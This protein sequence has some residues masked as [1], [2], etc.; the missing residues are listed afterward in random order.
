METLTKI[1]T[2]RWTNAIFMKYM[3]PKNLMVGITQ[4]KHNWSITTISVPTLKILGQKNRSL[5]CKCN[6]YNVTESSW[7]YLIQFRNARQLY[8]S[9]KA[10]S[11]S[12]G[13]S[14]SY[15]VSKSS[16]LRISYFYKKSNF[17]IMLEV[18]WCTFSAVL[19]NC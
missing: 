11:Y 14:F 18:L 7:R 12:N 6:I 3:K 17:D 4:E 16:S 13:R 5:T 2:I 9:I 15:L 10:L 1:K 19:V 8:N